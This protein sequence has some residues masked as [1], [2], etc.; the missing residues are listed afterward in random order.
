LGTLGGASSSATDISA[1]GSAICGHSYVSAGDPYAFRWV[2]GVG[3]EQIGTF[4]SFAL[5]ISG[6]GKTVTGFETGSAGIYKAFRWT[7][8]GGF[9]FNIA[10]NF[11]QGNA[12]S[13]DGSIIVGDYG[14]GAFRFSNAGGLE[15]LNQVYATLLTSGSDLFIALDIS[16]DGQ[17]IV[18]QGTNGTTLQDEGFLLAINGI[19]SIDELSGYPSDFVLNQNYPNPFNPLTTISFSIPKEE[20]VSLKV[21]N[22]LGE[23]VTELVNETKP[24]GNYS[25]SYNANSLP[26]GIYFYKIS[27]GSFSKTRKMILLK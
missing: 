9:E 15:S 24:A 25:L 26:S 22:S 13:G 12:V 20:F 8:T 3:M 10:G 6:D 4:Y 14:N 21:F 2:E 5:G 19:N 1:N 17:F 27:A 16:F 11:S 18:G 23:E 7:E